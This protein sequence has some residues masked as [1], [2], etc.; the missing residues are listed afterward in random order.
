MRTAVRILAGIFVFSAV[1]VG[2]SGVA[3]AEE[4]EG[5]SQPIS[6]ADIQ[7]IS[8][9]EDAADTV[10]YDLPS[11]TMFVVTHDE[12]YLVF[13]EHERQAGI[14]TVSGEDITRDIS[15]VHPD[16][17]A[18]QEDIRI[19]MAEETSIQTDGEEASYTEVRDSPEQFDMEVVEVEVQYTQS[20][21][22]AD[23][24]GTSVSEYSVVGETERTLPEMSTA[25]TEFAAAT[26]LDLSIEEYDGSLAFAFAPD[27]DDRL[28]LTGRH[29]AFQMS[30]EARVTLAVLADD[31]NSGHIL[32]DAQPAGEF[33]SASSIARGEH[34]PGEI[35]QM[36][37]DAAGASI[38]TREALVSAARCA[39]DSVANPVTACLPLVTDSVVYTGV[40]AENPSSG[41]IVPLIGI[42]NHR[43]DLLAEPFGGEYQIGGEVVAAED[44]NIDIPGQYA[45]RVEQL[46]RTGDGD[47]IDSLQAEAENMEDAVIEELESY[48][49]EDAETPQRDLGDSSDDEA[50]QPQIEADEV[51]PLDE[52]ELSVADVEYDPQYA[53]EGEKTRA[54]I[55]IENTGNEPVETAILVEY[56]REE[57]TTELV[58]LDIGESTIISVEREVSGSVRGT[59]FVNGE[60]VGQLGSPPDTETPESDD[61]SVAQDTP[62]D[63]SFA[64]GSGFGIV[65]TLTA[66]ILVF[67]RL[68][69]E[70][71]L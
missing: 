27:Q 48:A 7:V 10:G 49:G 60:S 64:D 9:L 25:P 54:D 33:T 58:S 57:L 44:L 28:L 45:I 22:L 4:I 61:G 11:N 47:F 50:T 12:V 3:A 39:P 38:S 66:L 51:V 67:A 18:D 52:L 23:V 31:D 65:A 63:D 20:V 8:E 42:S 21:V 24:P 43:Q 17:E 62:G 29:P 71:R 15:R 53:E 41:E 56:A 40:A 32:V 5:I 70:S 2:M 36:E 46:E 19:L 1:L 26:T 16:F 37:A 55:T 59:L 35:V 69:S 6:E 13:T 34:T 68:H 14:A 30:G